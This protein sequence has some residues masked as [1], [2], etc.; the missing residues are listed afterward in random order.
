MTLTNWPA[1]SSVEHHWRP[2]ANVA[3]AGYPLRLNTADETVALLAGVHR[4]TEA[5]EAVERERLEAEK[6]ARLAEHQRHWDT[7]KAQRE[8]V[9]S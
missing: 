9:K 1:R 3:D 7:N 4:A 2:F 5:A 6:R 8:A